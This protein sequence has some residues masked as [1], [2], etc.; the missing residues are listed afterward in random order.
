MR[1]WPCP[2]DDLYV[3]M[4]FATVLDEKGLD[5]ATQD[6]GDLLRNAQ[7]RLRHAS[8]AARRTL[9]RGVPTTLAGTP[10]Y[11]AHA[12]DIDS[13]IESDFT[14]LMTPGMPIAANELA[15]R[16]GRVMNYGDGIYGGMSVFCM[17]ATACFEDDPRRIVEAGVACLGTRSPYALPIRAVLQWHADQSGD[18]TETWQLIADKWD[19]RGSCPNGALRAFNINAKLNGA[20]LALGLL[21]GDWDSERT[22]RTSPPAGQDWDCNPSNAC[23]IVGMMLGHEANPDR[24]TS[25]IPAISNKKFSNTDFTFL[26]MVDSTQKRAIARAEKHGGHIEGVRLVV[27]RQDAQPAELQLGDDYGSP[28]KRIPASDV[29]QNWKGAWQEQ[30]I[31]DRRGTDWQG[32]VAGPQAT[33]ATIS[34]LGSGAIVTGPNLPTGGTAKVY[35]G[36]ALHREVEA[37]PDEDNHKYGESSMACLRARKGVADSAA[38]RARRTTRRIGRQRS[39]GQEPGRVP[40]VGWRCGD[41]PAFECIPA[42]GLTCNR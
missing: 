20:Y 26:G 25:G 5:A 31:I 40:I 6:F 42:G 38:R 15:L 37:Y 14:G 21:Y 27:K 12:N 19:K 8:L 9:Q 36:G 4:P 28:V 39:R 35:S 18:W 3:E 1:N 34:F 10:Q 33:E 13:Q 23:G 7:Y 2:Q 16:A 41:I 32:R 17:Y 24:W 22:L 29:R 30:L 11:N